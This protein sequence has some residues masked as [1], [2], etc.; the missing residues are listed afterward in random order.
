[1]T[2]TTLTVR[3]TGQAVVPAPQSEVLAVV[4][5]IERAS[6][7][8][9]VDIEKMQKLF[10]LREKVR[11]QTARDDFVA[12]KIRV[13]SELPVI[14]TQGRIDLGKG[15]P[16]RYARWEDINETIKPILRDHGF[17]LSFRT[18]HSEGK[19]TVTAVLAHVAGHTEE[20]TIYLPPDSSGA[21]S[22]VQGVGSAVSYGKRYTTAALLNLTWGGED[23]DGNDGKHQA[24]SS[25]HHA[26]LVEA[27]TAAGVDPTKLAM[28]FAVDDLRELPESKYDAAMAKISAKKVKPAVHRNSA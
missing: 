2:D 27:A 1:M 25:E 5:M 6:K 9:S 18:G 12:A 3:G 15:R 28:V 26:S 20:T 11:A 14:R 21:K 24:I 8:P 13:Q 23:D 16:L 17:D 4:Q 22:A 7:D 10:E 19:T